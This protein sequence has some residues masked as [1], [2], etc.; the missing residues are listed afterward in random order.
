M[1][2]RRRWAFQ[3]AK[4]GIVTGRTS[5]GM[6]GHPGGW[7]RFQVGDQDLGPVDNDLVSSADRVVQGQSAR[8]VGAIAEVGEM[9]GPSAPII[10]YEVDRAADRDGVPVAPLPG[11]PPRGGRGPLQPAAPTI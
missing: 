9:A 6:R 10:F 5:V 2:I 11:R 1:L 4:S 3:A 8:V 7:D